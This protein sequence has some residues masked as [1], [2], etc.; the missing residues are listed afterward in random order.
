MTTFPSRSD[1]QPPEDGACATRL[2]RLAAVGAEGTLVIEDPRGGLAPAVASL[3]LGPVQPGD[4]VVAAFPDAGPAIALGAVAAAAL[5][6]A[7]LA[8][9]A[10]GNRIVVSGREEIELVCGRASIRLQADGKI[11]IA[12]ETVI[13]RATGT[14]TLEGAVVKVN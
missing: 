14:N 9:V 6:A 1:A 8:V 13:S 11:V 10:D 3:A 4:L 12:G 5:A 2:A 7:P